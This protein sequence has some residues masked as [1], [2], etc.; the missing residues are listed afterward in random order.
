MRTLFMQPHSVIFW[1]IALA[2]KRK[3]LQIDM[4]YFE[5]LQVTAS[6]ATDD[7]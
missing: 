1:S 6:V 5:T 2:W 4:T 3:E 7:M